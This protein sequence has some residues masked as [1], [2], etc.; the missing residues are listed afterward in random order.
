M[1]SS[2]ARQLQQLACSL[3]NL[4]GPTET[5][6]WST[7]AALEGNCT[8]PPGIGCAIWNTQLYVLDAGLQ[9]VPPGTAGELY[10]AGT[11]VARGYLNRH[12][13][14]AER[15]IANPYGPPGSRMY[16]TGDIVRW[17]EDG[18]LDY[19]GRADHQ[20]KFGVPN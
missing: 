8:E 6:I 14:T 19:I 1:Q 18:S 16:R 17:R 5:T 12:A 13:L 11:G 9:P 3:T 2:L 10:V 4:Y 20:V 15:F 7:A